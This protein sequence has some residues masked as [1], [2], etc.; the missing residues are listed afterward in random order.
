MK[1]SI[2]IALMTVITFA[3]A[4]GQNTGLVEDFNDNTLTG[5]QGT[6]DYQ[7]GAS[8]GVLYIEADKRVTWNSFTFSFTA[9]DISA[10][11]IVSLAVRTDRDFNLGFSVWDTDGKYD[12]P[13]STYQE[14]VS[15]D[16]FIE[17]V[18][19]F[20][21]AKEADLKKICMLN[22]VF[23]P[24]AAQS[25]KGNVI[26]DDLKI[27]S[28]AV[29]TPSMT[30]VPAQFV[31]INSGETE[32]PFRGVS[33]PVAGVKPVTITATSS[34]PSLVPDPVV[35]YTSPQK[36]G[37][38]KFKPAADRTGTATITVTV[39]GNA[40]GIKTVP[41]DVTVE[42]NRPPIMDKPEQP[43]MIQAG[44]PAELLLTGIDDGNPNAVQ[45]VILAAASSNAAKMPAPAVLRN[46]AEP[47]ARLLLSPMPGVSGEVSVTVALRDD[48]GTA[49]GG[50][51][52]NSVVFAVQIYNDAV[53]H[54]PTLD[55]IEDRSVLED[56][57]GQTLSLTGISNGDPGSGQTLVLSASSSN[58]WLVPDPSVE[59]AAGDSSAVLTFSPAAGR[60][61]TATVTVRV[62][63][64]G[65]TPD[66]NGDASIVRTFVITVRSKPTVGFEQT[67]DDNVLPP[68]WPPDFGGLGEDCHRCSVEDGV[69]KIEIDKNRTGNIWAGLWFQ[70]SEE[71]D[72]SQFPYI[73]ITM[74]T[75]NPGTPMLIFLWD[76]FDHYNTGKTVSFNVTGEFVE[77]FF[78]FTGLDLQGDGIQVDFT[79]IKAL[80]INFDPGNRP[81][82][83]GDFFFDDFRVGTFAHRA[84]AV[85]KV[86]MDPV[87]DFTV[88][89]NC[90]T[91]TVR[92][93][94]LGDGGDGSLPVTLKATSSYKA[95]IPV[96]VL[97]GVSEG[98]ATLTFAP[99]ADKTGTS[100]ITVTASAEGSTNAVRTFKIFVADLNPDLAKDVSVDTLKT[101]QAIDGFGAFMG[102]GGGT[103][104]P[105]AISL[106]GDI[107]M[108]MAR[109]GIIED[110]FEPV[111]DNSDPDIID[112]SRFHKEGLPLETMRLL[113]N[114][115]GLE[116]FILTVWSPPAW[117]KR[118]KS[119]NADDW[120][121]DNK[122]EPFYYEEYAEHLTAV[123]KTI[124]YETGVELAAVSLQNEPQFNEFYA[125]CVVNPDEM[126]DMIKV[127]GARFER[128]GIRT[129]IYWAEALPAQ[130][131][132]Q[133]YIM[134]VKN[135]P[136][137]RRYGD[138]VAIHNYDAD[139][140]N[141]G[142]AGADEWA[143]IY[144]WAQSGET[145]C[146]TW[147]TETSG[148]ANSWDG[149][150]ELAGN[151]FN[152]LVYG[153]ASAWVFWSFTVSGGSEE[154]GLVVDNEPTSRFY[155]SKQYY[156]FIRP[157]AV[158]VDVSSA[159]ADVPA[160]AFMNGR[161]GTLAVIL[162]NK[163][164]VPK[165]VRISG[166]GVPSSLQS[167][168]TADRRNCESGPAV[169]SD[170]LLLLPPSSVTT[171]SGSTG[172]GSS[173]EGRAGGVPERF[174][175]FQNYPNPFNPET[176]IE[177][178]IPRP[179]PV[180]VKIFDVLGREVR[181]LVHADFQAGRHRIRWDGRDGAGRQ[182][183]SGLYLVRLSA[184]DF[185]G[186]KKGFLI[187]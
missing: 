19:D 61:G 20:S 185:A 125:S 77:Y 117:M 63:D 130:G 94:G 131:A 174:R 135:D 149:A 93:T 82:F 14:I 103:A 148:H 58:A 44:L 153:N 166:A 132:I 119:L 162:I 172:S 91:Q 110:E 65:G 178:E 37:M 24:G 98:A 3:F 55:P 177:F 80:L 129:K 138:I 90:G 165:A 118:N 167:F 60:T 184:G 30:A 123:I 176:T 113:K 108:S 128:E 46:D 25:F 104:T 32:V 109:F 15:T 34:N 175:L 4:A 161:E 180:T 92:I 38:L 10:N 105:L 39:S 29:R 164:N 64:D 160:A 151:I 102:S 72:L 71:L 36:T 28:A 127:V 114:R 154:Y 126:R 59:Y 57:P 173:A 140:I 136:V 12:Y 100:T 97:S 115:N 101:H 35:V 85:P 40:P 27:G 183:A 17:Y 84:P 171:L 73:S 21:K 8:D 144:G 170:G 159:D 145:K 56:S 152:A 47:S 124:Q 69:L 121:T 50:L 88:P 23:N 67:F 96:P 146:P 86:T 186:V 79:R 62:S 48:G 99:V 75:S 74:K 143:R 41:F 22:F 43:L 31:Y 9:I 139:G 18:F 147:M 52:S 51:D 13:P 78:D 81:L 112:W 111:N 181:T 11:P 157:G 163:S 53:N 142:G 116:N 134:A 182:A 187:R 49:D 5:W 26:F 83:A 106:A 158:R 89:K 141:V 155:I 2:L 1:R 133:N 179:S 16:H 76:A 66:N 107:G 6:G 122:L 95:L 54:P 120:A 150:L 7:L 87:P 42:K 45:N 168:T 137:A 33:D 169:G 70:I 68:Q 156:Q